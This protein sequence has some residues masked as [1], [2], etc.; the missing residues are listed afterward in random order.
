MKNLVP[1]ELIESRIYVFRGQKVMLDRDLAKLYGVETKVFKQ[2]VRRNLDRFPDDFMFQLS[3]GELTN[4]RSQ[5]VT[6]NSDKMGLRY[7]PFVFTE[8]GIAM[9]SSVLNSKRAIA[10]NVQIM[11]TFVNIRNMAVDN[12]D[13]HKK[14]EFLEKNYDQ[15]FKIVFDALRKLIADDT[16]SKDRPEIGFKLSSKR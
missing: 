14:I 11:R 15:Q 4:W 7:Q 13:I 16:D 12:A 3:K 2:T 6:S 8:Q 5:F 1:A 9:L 10:I